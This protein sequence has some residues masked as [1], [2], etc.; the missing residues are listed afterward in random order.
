[1]KDFV[2]AFRAQQSLAG[3]RSAT[4][5]MAALSLENCGLKRRCGPWHVWQQQDQVGCTDIDAQLREQG[6][7]LSSM[8][9]LM[10]EDVQKNV[11]Q[12]LPAFDA[13]LGCVFKRL[14]SRFRDAKPGKCFA[15]RLNQMMSPTT[16]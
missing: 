3:R 5:I 9:G 12:Q 14:S 11:T 2:T 8:M 16:I 10:I 7:R 6:G 15:I 1:M 13:L 4:T